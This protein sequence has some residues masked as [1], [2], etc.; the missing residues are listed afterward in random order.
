MVAKFNAS[1]EQ[2][3]TFVTIDV[4]DK[5]ETIVNGI[6]YCVYPGEYVTFLDVYTQSTAHLQ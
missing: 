4:A 1:T 5:L 2:G 6:F 3:L